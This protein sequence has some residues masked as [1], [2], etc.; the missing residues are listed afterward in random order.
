MWEMIETSL[1]SDVL[2]L[3]ARG[4]TLLGFSDDPRAEETL[5]SLVQRLP[6]TWLRWKVTERSLRLF[7]TNSWAKYWFQ[8][9]LEV[10]DDAMAWSSFR[11][12]LRCVDSRFA[13]WKQ[14]VIER[15]VEHERTESRM[16]FLEINTNDVQHSIQDNEKDLREQF[17]GHKILE[18]QAW[19]WL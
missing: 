14:D 11:L 12:F 5:Q 10:E 1:T 13:H 16:V 2:F 19:P 18:R 17:L 7:H 15:S 9:F 8:R 4:I 6:D 3:R